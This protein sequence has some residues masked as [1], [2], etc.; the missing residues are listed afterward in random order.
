MLG[1]IKPRFFAEVDIDPLPTEQ[2]RAIAQLSVLA[3]REA[4]LL[5]ELVAEK[6]KY[7]DLTI[8]KIYN[9][10]KRGN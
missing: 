8:N 9:K 5:R 10:M 1:G 6:E 3:Q 7:Y 4:K 2:Q